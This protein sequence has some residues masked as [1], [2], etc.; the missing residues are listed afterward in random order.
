MGRLSVT[1]T[2]ALR[3][4]VVACGALAASLVAHCAAA[5]DLAL[6]ATAPVAWAGLLAAVTLVGARRGFRPRGLLGS[7]AA[8]VAAQTAIHASM[9]WAPWAFGLAPHHHDAA[10]VTA[11][12]L[13]AHAAAA[14]V[15]ALLAARLEVWLMRAMSAAAAVRRWL[16][17]RPGPRPA[18]EAVP[19]S[20]GHTPRL[21]S[22]GGVPC[23]GPPLLHAA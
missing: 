7:F 1:H 13:V 17:P 10:I 22:R 2:L 8:M 19:G 3:R 23:R 11:P 5:G 15:L 18:D 12:A 14:I 6:T 21:A 20:H 4:L 16:T 9:T